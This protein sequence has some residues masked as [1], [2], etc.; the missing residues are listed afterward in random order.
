[1]NRKRCQRNSRIIPLL[2]LYFCAMKLTHII[3]LV[4]IAVAIGFIISMVSDYSSYETF[5]T[6]KGENARDFEVVGYLVKEKPMEYDP[7]KDPNYFSFWLRDKN[8]DERKVI[9]IGTKP[10]DFERSEEIV[11]NGRMQGEEFHAKKILM[12]CPSKYKNDRIA[13]AN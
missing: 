6:A 3:G 10:Q 13:V 8:K 7:K 11:L 4:I 5:A 2:P 9:F 1:M 12:K